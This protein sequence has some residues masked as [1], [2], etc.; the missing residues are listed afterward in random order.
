MRLFF[1]C[2]SPAWLL[3]SSLAHSLQL[4]WDGR[5]I[6]CCTIFPLELH[7]LSLWNC[8]PI[9]YF[10]KSSFHHQTNRVCMKKNP[11]IL[12]FLPLCCYRKIPNTPILTKF[13]PENLKPA[14]GRTNS[15]PQHD[16]P[17]AAFLPQEGSG[18]FHSSR[19]LWALSE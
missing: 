14:D 11:S 6:W 9:A 19:R 17:G 13:P 3:C 5:C 2:F 18:S 15:L 12:L 1:S 16:I 10:C 8:T 4:G 7:N